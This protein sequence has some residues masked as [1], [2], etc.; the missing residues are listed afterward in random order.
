MNKETHDRLINHEPEA[1]IK[2]EYHVIEKKKNELSNYENDGWERD[3]QV[4]ST[5]YGGNNRNIYY[6]I[7]MK[8][9]SNEQQ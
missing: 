8:R 2:Y 1:N 6:S 5:Y 7:L 3:G 4:M 9:I